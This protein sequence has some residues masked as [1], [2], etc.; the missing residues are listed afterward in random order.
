MEWLRSNIRHGTR[1]A[2]LALVVQFVLSFGHVHGIAAHAA[3]AIHAT[4][5]LPAPSHDPD[6]HPDDFCAICAVV[7]LTSTAL[8]AV[9]PA[10]PVPQAF[11]LVHPPAIATVV[12]SRAAC[13]AFQSRAPPRS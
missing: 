13:A 3:P 9:P 10:L 11:E 2:L 7:A 6:Q 8:A 4:H 1:L 12:H 5:H